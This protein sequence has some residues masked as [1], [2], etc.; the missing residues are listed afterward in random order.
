MVVCTV[1]HNFLGESLQLFG[2]GQLP[3]DQQKA[4]LQKVRTVC[5]LFDGIASVLKDALVTVDVGNLGDAA[6]SVH[7]GRIVGAG[8]GACLT[9]DVA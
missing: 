8:D 3:V 5:Q 9:F 2:S 1:L 4:D 6:N 7:I